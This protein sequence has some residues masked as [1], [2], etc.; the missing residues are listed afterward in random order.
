MAFSL[1]RQCRHGVLRVGWSV[2]ELI[3]AISIIGLGAA[4]TSGAV[5]KVRAVS[6]RM[7]V[8]SWKFQRKFGDVP[9]RKAPVKVLF[10]G[11]SYIYSNDLPGAVVALAEARNE[12][13]KLIVDQT[14]GG[15]G[16]L[17]SLWD[18]GS[19]AGKIRSKDWDIVV[20]QERRGRPVDRTGPD[21]L[22][23]EYGR[24]TLFVPYAKKFDQV[25]RDRGAITMFMMTW[26]VPALVGTTQDLW[27]DSIDALAKDLHAEVSPAG[28]AL[29]IVL[30]QK[31][32]FPFYADAYPGHPTPAG[33]YLIACCF[34]AAIYGKDP[35]GLPP[36]VITA[37]GAFVGVNPADA[38][39]VQSAAWD[40]VVET[41]KRIGL[42]AR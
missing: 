38:R 39:L 28:R 20:L 25:I 11:N 35:V 10:V 1:Y 34:Y 29:E 6:T 40:A 14:T 27:T 9:A 41:K 21:G 13:P 32:T 23:G 3:T 5:M 12:T 30:R 4:L 31:P 18:A 37:H 24:N 42:T 15:A 22:G 7:E 8:E 33:T 26:K 16:T 2:L 17:E 36:C 19:A